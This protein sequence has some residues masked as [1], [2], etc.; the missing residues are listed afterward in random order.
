[1]YI[2]RTAITSIFACVCLAETAWSEC[3]TYDGLGRLERTI[4]DSANSPAV[5]YVLDEHGNRVQV[6][7]ASSSTSICEQPDGVVDGGEASFVSSA[8]YQF[9]S[10][11][12]ASGN[13]P[14]IADDEE[15]SLIV[16][17]STIVR[18][19]QGD[20]DPDGDQLSIYQFSV[21]TGADLISITLNGD[22]MLVQAISGPG[23]SRVWYTA[24]DGRGGFDAGII[25]IRIVEQETNDCNSFGLNVPCG[26][27][28]E[29]NGIEP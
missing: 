21:A 25:Q 17:T 15:I 26:D 10:G 3:Y 18:P 2:L 1:M 13:N 22:E 27:E 6:A 24:A 16:G 28:F 11:P 19:L 20:T 23:L 9:T 7:T 5:Q 12:S 29:F 4:F 14:P 8:D